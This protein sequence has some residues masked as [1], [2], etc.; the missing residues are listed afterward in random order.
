[1]YRKTIWMLLWM[2]LCSPCV[3]SLWAG[4]VGQLFSFGDSGIDNGNVFAVTDGLEPADPYWEGRF[5]IGQNDLLFAGS[6]PPDPADVAADM[7]EAFLL[8]Y[9][10]GARR[11]IFP[12][13]FP[14]QLMPGVVNDASVDLDQVADWVAQVNAEADALIAEFK[15]TH[16]DVIVIRTDLTRLISK[17]YAKGL[18]A[19][20]RLSRGERYSLNLDYNGAWAGDALAQSFNIAFV[21][22][23]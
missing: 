19:G 1:M 12:T 8:A 4:S 11:F 2:F 6:S 9:E 16:P 23:Y 17:V 18:L 21:L 22:A 14:L 7:L 3:P 20:L 5:S 10:N 13:L 15:A